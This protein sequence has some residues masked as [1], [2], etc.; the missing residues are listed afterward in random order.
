[1]LGAVERRNVGACTLT[2][3]VV[4]SVM[5]PD[6]PVIVTGVVP[7]GAEALAVSVRTL[8]PD[9]GFV[10]QDAVTPLGSVEVI[11][12]VTLPENPPASVMAIVVV[13]D[14]P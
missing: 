6:V 4:V 13:L 11:A 14:A 8:L 10:P 1:V 7:P 12:S 5:A 9:V 2:E 3:I